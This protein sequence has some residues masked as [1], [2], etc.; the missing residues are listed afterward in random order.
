MYWTLVIVFNVKSKDMD[1]KILCLEDELFIH[2]MVIDK[3]MALNREFYHAITNE[4]ASELIKEHGD[5]DLIIS[6]FQLENGSVV[7]FFDYLRDEGLEIP[8]IIFSGLIEKEIRERISY[9]DLIT[10]IAKPDFE[11]LAA[12]LDVFEKECIE[13]PRYGQMN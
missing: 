6:D 13:H 11:G 9:E 12:C 4:Q 5:F 8:T 3:C 2:Q 7:Q 1:M 10:I